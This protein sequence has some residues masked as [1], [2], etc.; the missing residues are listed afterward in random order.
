MRPKTVIIFLILIVAL[1]LSGYYV[2]LDTLSLSEIFRDRGNTAA[3]ISLDLIDFDTTLTRYDLHRLGK[4]SGY[5]QQRI[6]DV[7]SIKDR[8]AGQA[9]I[10]K[11]VAEM[12]KDPSMKK[13]VH[14]FLGLGKKTM[15]RFLKMVM[16]DTTEPLN[17]PQMEPP[18]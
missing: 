5:W 15:L 14:R 17:D 7:N 8:Q 4:K 18:H 11:L 1:F 9:E 10:D 6:R 3:D 12:K 2:F 16:T 13:I